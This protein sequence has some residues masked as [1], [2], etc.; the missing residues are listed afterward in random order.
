MTVPFIDLKSFGRKKTTIMNMI[1]SF[2][3]NG[4][5]GYFV[6]I[7]NISAYTWIAA[8]ITIFN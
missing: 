7:K 1:L 3:F 2:I 4:L 5:G 8:V 6:Y